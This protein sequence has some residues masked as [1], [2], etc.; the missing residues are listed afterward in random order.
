MKSWRDMRNSGGPGVRGFLRWWIGALASWLPLRWRGFLGLA[1]DR[2]LLEAQDET[3]E[4]SR[5]S[6]DGTATMATLP[7]PLDAAGLSAL[8]PATVAGLPRWLLLP[9]GQVLR[10]P[11]GLPA[12]AADRLREVV[13]FEIDRQTPF[14]AA[15]VHYDVRMLGRRGDRIEV[16]LVAVPRAALD[17]ALARLG[18]LAT[19]LAG[20]DV[21][22]GNGEPL[23]VNLL[24]AAVR[25]RREDPM[26]R[27]NVVL[28]VCAVA[29]L[30]AAGAQMLHNRRAAADA[31]AQAI[32]ARIDEARRAATQRQQLV[33]LV[34]GMAFLERQRAARPAMVEVLDE[35]TTRLLDNSFLE[36]LSVQGDQLT[37]VGLSA[38]APSLVGQMDGARSWRNPA[39]AGA[40]QSD[41][42]TRRDR[43]SLTATLAAPAPRPPAEPAR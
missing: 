15:Q 12:A 43:F 19:T 35:V 39:L 28:A 42:V 26:R 32:D 22:D 7:L 14:N 24:P 11:L 5:Q 20:V 41:P 40:L 2:L 25:S 9:A 23:G 4:L 34:D 37:L 31:L 1:E 13:G 21:V 27:W 30:V 18:T 8:L 17:R 33:D 38:D 6:L 3:A 10:R 36:K 29:A 16:E